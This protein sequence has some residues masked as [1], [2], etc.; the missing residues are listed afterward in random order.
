MMNGNGRL[1]ES[2]VLQRNSVTGNDS[3]EE[4]VLLERMSQDENETDTLPLNGIAEVLTVE[5]AL[6]GKLLLLGKNIF[7]D[8]RFQLDFEM[9]SSIP[10]PPITPLSTSETDQ[11][12]R[13]SLLSQNP[14]P[15]ATTSS[16]SRP[17][18]PQSKPRKITIAT[19]SGQ[20]QVLPSHQASA[21]SVNDPNT[22]P[23]PIQKLY[24]PDFLSSDSAFQRF[25]ELSLHSGHSKEQSPNDPPTPRR[26]DSKLRGKESS[27]DLLRQKIYASKIDYRRFFQ[28]LESAPSNVPHPVYVPTGADSSLV[29]HG[30]KLNDD[31]LFLQIVSSV[32]MDYA[33]LLYS[34]MTAL[35]DMS[36]EWQLHYLQVWQHHLSLRSLQ[37]HGF[38]LKLNDEAQ[39]ENLK[40]AKA[41]DAKSYMKHGL[42]TPLVDQYLSL[43][44]LSNANMPLSVR[45]EHECHH[46]GNQDVN[47]PTSQVKA[48]SSFSKQQGRTSSDT[49]IHN[50]KKQ[51][52]ADQ[53]PI[54]E[55]HRSSALSGEVVPDLKS[56]HRVRPQSPE[57]HFHRPIPKVIGTSEEQSPHGEKL[58]AGPF[59]LTNQIKET[60]LPPLPYSQTSKP[61][62]RS[63]RDVSPSVYPGSDRS[64]YESDRR[65][66]SSVE[67]PTQFS[68]RPA[69]IM[70]E[71]LGGAEKPM[72][73]TSSTRPDNIPST[74]RGL[75]NPRLGDSPPSY[76]TSGS[77][78]P[79]V[80]GAYHH[81]H[82]HQHHPRMP[83]PGPPHM[84]PQHPLTESYYPAQ[85]ISKDSPWGSR[86]LSHYPSGIGCTLFFDSHGSRVSLYKISC[87]FLLLVFARFDHFPRVFSH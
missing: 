24:P 5:T 55:V 73:S 50:P 54:V 32:K 30:L 86:S 43:S 47:P 7:A 42:L 69:K 6:I 40:P 26:V 87:F 4:K 11:S 41:S 62:A 85:H 46:T 79:P 80:Q 63:Y 39:H 36:M 57:K 81:H 67:S 76:P 82:H 70:G 45:Y 65:L 71:G 49:L 3:E 37:K 23:D 20:E 33:G 31:P 74:S 25:P 2:N 13:N 48:G 84:G 16:S 52:T 75:V 22:V 68:S 38:G 9:N 66:R 51:K 19:P 61:P 64:P 18:S 78:H 72:Y 8:R 77:Y 15:H 60:G 58:V 29:K 10:P 59:D 35:S 44:S 27:V 12:T 56:L 14:L 1:M 34:F 21:S 17:N 28:Y 53:H 83:K